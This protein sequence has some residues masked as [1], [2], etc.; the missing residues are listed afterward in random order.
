MMKLIKSGLPISLKDQ[1]D[2]KGVN[3]TMSYVGWI[4]Q[5]AKENAVITDILLQQGVSL[6]SQHIDV[7][8]GSLPNNAQ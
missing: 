8:N 1:I 2:V 7:P 5:K 6:T 3:H 4:G